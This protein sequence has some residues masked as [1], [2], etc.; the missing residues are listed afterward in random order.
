[1]AHHDNKPRR[2]LDET[3]EFA[4]AVELAR[5]MTSEEDTLI[6][7]TS[8]HSH[9]FTYNGYPWRHRDVLGLVDGSIATDGLPYETLSYAVG[10]GYSRAYDSM[11]RTDLR[12]YNY[13]FTDQL[14]IATVPKDTGNHAADDVGVYA[15]GPFSHLF[16]GS[17]EQNIVALSMAYAAKIEPYLGPNQSTTEKSDTDDARSLVAMIPLLILL[18]VISIF[19]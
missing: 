5:T 14:H 6:V 19:I 9:A 17:Y 4:R 3:A 2:A 10:P 1:M 7:V 12:G 11:G 8:D 15:I 16:Q 13:K 18:S